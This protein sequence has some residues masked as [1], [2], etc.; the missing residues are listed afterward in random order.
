MAEFLLLAALLIVGAVAA[1]LFGL[2]RTAGA[3]DLLMAVQLLGTGAVAILL[4]LSGAGA[5]AALLDVALTLALLSAFAVAALN[6]GLLR[7]AAPDR[8]DGT[9]R[10]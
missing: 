4:L 9:D 10:P 8:P 2:R 5:G 6:A 1:G 3:P 7:A